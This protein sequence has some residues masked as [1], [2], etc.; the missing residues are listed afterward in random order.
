[1]VADP[2]RV[3]QST[4]ELRVDDKNQKEKNLVETRN[5]KTWYLGM[6]IYFVLIGLQT[7]QCQGPVVLS[8]VNAIQQI[9]RYSADK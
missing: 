4:V 1:M 7:S 3:L 8:V 5:F 2:R 6:F 9:N